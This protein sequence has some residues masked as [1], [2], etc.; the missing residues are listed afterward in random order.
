MDLD[1]AGRRAVVAGASRG[2]GLEIARTLSGHGVS[3]AICARRAEGLE[4]ARKELEGDSAV[5]ARPTDLSDAADTKAFV[6]QALAALGGL[7]I[8]I[9]CASGFSDPSEGGWS[10][11]FEIDVLAAL[12]GLEI[13][14]PALQA[15]GTGSIVLIGSTASL[16][17]FARPGAAPNTYGA[18]KAAQRVLVNDL[19]QMWGRYGIRAN[20]VSPG[21]VL[22]EGG[23][24]GRLRDEQ[25]EQYNLLL[26][27]F[28]ARRLV[29]PDEVARVVAFIASPAA[30][31]ING[32]H[33]VVDG[34]QNKAVQ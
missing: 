11:T 26:K 1:L 28:P 25:P 34:A 2:I 24:W 5:F 22:V 13:A 16:Q 19:A 23:T 30:S 31:G 17:W 14:L 20:A 10:K 33:I 29:M 15:S 8:Y 7:D 27:Q 32:T 3:L 6:E 4:Q 18:A 9:H 21:S 12:R